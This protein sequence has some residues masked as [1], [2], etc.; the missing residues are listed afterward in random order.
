MPSLSTLDLGQSMPHSFPHLQRGNNAGAYFRGQLCSGPSFPFPSQ[1]GCSAGW[2][3]GHAF[4]SWASAF[5][6]ASSSPYCPSPG[7]RPHLPEHPGSETFFALLQ[8][9]PIHELTSP[10]TEKLDYHTPPTRLCLLHP[11][12]VAELLS[13]WSPLICRETLV[14][15]TPCPQGPSSP[16]LLSTPAFS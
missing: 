6:P 12:P 13:S 3:Q 10:N 14:F 9:F 8:C 1:A 2:T 15:E 16:M 5:F 11:P 7:S 4:L